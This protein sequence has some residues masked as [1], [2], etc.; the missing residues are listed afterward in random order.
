[1]SSSDRGVSTSFERVV[2]RTHCPY[3]AL[4]CGIGLANDE[5]GDVVAQIRWKTAPLTKGGICSKGSTAWQQIHHDD[6]IT[7]P[8][9]RR[10]G[11]FVPSSWD[12]ALDLAVAGFQRIRSEHGA[13]ANALLSGGS[14][15][16]EKAYLLGKLARLGLGT[17]HIDYNGRF[18][19]VSAGAANLR[20]FGLDRAMTPFDELRSCDVIVVVGANLSD[21]YP[22]MLPTA[23]AKARRNGA[24]VVVIDPRFGRWVD[25]NDLRLAIRPGSDGAL[26]LGLL[27]EVERAGLVDRDY[28]AERT[29]GFDEALTAA[30]SWTPDAVAAATD[31]PAETLRGVARL[32]GTAERC[33]ILHARGAEQQTM[34]T[35][36]V[37]AMLNL[38]LACGLPGRPGCGIN[39]LTGQRNGQGGREWGQRCNQLPAGRHIDDAAHRSVVVERWG[40]EPGRLP[41]SGATYVEILQMAGR[42]EVRGLLSISNNPSISAP[43]LERTESQLAELDHVVVIDPFLSDFAARHADVV[44]PGSTWAEEEGTITTIEGRVLRCDQATEP[45]AGRADLEVIRGLADRLGVGTH[46]AFDRGREVWE[47]MR[48][49]S[50]GG[51]NDYAGITW[52]RARDGV[53]WPCPTEDHPGT[54]QL[55]VERFAT[56][57]GRA[58][59]HPVEAS[60]PPL[61]VDEDYPFVLTTGRHLAQYLSG[62]QTKRIAD[63]NDKAPA[64]YVELHPDAAASLGLDELDH[65]VLVSRLA[66]SVVPW[67]AN[68]K[69]RADTVFMPYHWRQCNVH[70]DDDLDPISKMP[71]FKY[72]PI[73]V[74]R[75]ETDADADSGLETGMTA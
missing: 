65:V 40:I 10:D 67:R 5:N 59:F 49:V 27:A 70:V 17:P 58:R 51:P 4:N 45:V 20:A 2:T 53:F 21:A 12:E 71:G 75:L 16:N 18:C 32:I 15:T 22:V 43:H 69:L 46:F 11:E 42:G 55:Y 3:C 73:A 54:P 9:V 64:P 57:D 50:A 36:N 24:T 68:P 30:R 8:L 47:E 25:D 44:L 52:D 29:V 14:L 35:D 74:S 7:T 31:V 56:P 62:N 26:F 23:I 19:M 37:S 66:R 13:D 63:Q 33:M 28:V 6:R 39:M 61:L 60:A 1:M 38:A 48:R 34:G 72:T 41:R